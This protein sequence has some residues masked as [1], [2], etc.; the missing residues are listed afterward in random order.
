MH[1]VFAFFLACFVFFFSLSLAAL[2]LY[3]PMMQLSLGS[4]FDQLPGHQASSTAVG[5]YPHFSNETVFTEVTSDLIT[6]L[7]EHF[8]V[9]ILSELCTAFTHFDHFFPVLH[10]NLIPWF[11]FHLVAFCII[12]ALFPCQG[13]SG[14]FLWLLFFFTLHQLVHLLSWFQLPVVYQV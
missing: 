12:C 9:L 11:F 1:S 7:H 5:L 2:G 14:F 4:N 3:L 10:D 6:K 13:Y 8:A